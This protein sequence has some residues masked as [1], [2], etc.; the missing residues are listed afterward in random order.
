MTTLFAHPPPP[1]PHTSRTRPSLDMQHQ[2]ANPSLLP[3]QPPS[4]PSSSSIMMSPLAPQSSRRSSTTTDTS[5]ELDFT[6]PPPSY[7][8]PPSYFASLGI[9]PGVSR[10]TR[11]ACLVVS[12]NDRLRLIGFPDEDISAVVDVVDNVFSTKWGVQGRTCPRKRVF[13][14]KLKGRPCE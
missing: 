11:Y 1:P 10:P 5:S 8:E 13:E 3:L 12:G 14:W 6:V 9:V 2:P 4:S 7:V